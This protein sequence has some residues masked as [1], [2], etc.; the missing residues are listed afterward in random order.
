ML[1]V[2]WNLHAS[3]QVMAKDKHFY[4]VYFEL[5]EEKEYIFTNGLW[6]LESAC[7]VFFHWRPN[8][9]HKELLYAKLQPNNKKE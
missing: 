7:L 9:R 6:A 2:T 4:M 3:F 8:I 5:E 1:H